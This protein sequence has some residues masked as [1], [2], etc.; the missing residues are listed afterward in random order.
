MN[1]CPYIPWNPKEDGPKLTSDNEARALKL[2]EHERQTIES[3]FKIWSSQEFYRYKDYNRNNKNPDNLIPI[4][5]SEIIQNWNKYMTN[6]DEYL[7]A[8]QKF[9]LHNKKF[10]DSLYFKPE[11]R[12]PIANS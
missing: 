7:S 11:D 2:R 9:I 6:I 3:M 12:P 4:D 10:R 5:L 1:N 8:D